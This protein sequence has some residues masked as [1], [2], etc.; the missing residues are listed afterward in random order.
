M[1]FYMDNKPISFSDFTNKILADNKLLEVSQ[2]VTQTQQTP[3]T[4]QPGN[5]NTAKFEAQMA[6]SLASIQTN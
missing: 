6:Q 4:V 3:Q 1:D 5:I 2:P